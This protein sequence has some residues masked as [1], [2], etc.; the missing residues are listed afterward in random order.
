MKNISASFVFI[1]IQTLDYTDAIKMI[2][3][4]CK[5]INQTEN[6]QLFR[7]FAPCNF[8]IHDNS[9]ENVVEAECLQL[10]SSSSKQFPSVQCVS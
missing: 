10:E 1:N 6:P 8:S 2:A 3:L 5:I 9:R 4:L 7:M